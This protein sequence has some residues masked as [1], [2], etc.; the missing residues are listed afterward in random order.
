MPGS[1]ACR[2]TRGVA[3]RS[4][5]PRAGREYHKRTAPETL[6]SETVDVRSPDT[7]RLPPGTAVQVVEV[8]VC[9]DDDI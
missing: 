6:V 2:T 7:A 4:G 1:S 5:A 9:R 3:A 8:E